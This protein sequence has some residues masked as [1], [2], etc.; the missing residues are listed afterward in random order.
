MVLLTYRHGLRATETCRLRTDDLDLDGHHILCRRGKGSVTNW[1]RLA[2]DEEDALHH[3]LRERQSEG[4]PNIFPNRSGAPLSRQHF[5]RIFR[6]LAAAAG[7]PPG[8]RHPHV[9]KHS[10]GTHLANA[11]VPVQVIQQ[12]LG[13]RNV[14]NTMVY[15][16]I[17]SEYVDR[18]VASAIESGAVV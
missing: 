16:A 14:Q 15:L 7:L 10:L 13:H 5:F 18:T 8:K 11:G 4:S 9:L 17:A 2:T 6:R 1:Q 3:W 12:R